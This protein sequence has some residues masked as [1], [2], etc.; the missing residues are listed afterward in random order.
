MYYVA[1]ICK[2]VVVGGSFRTRSTKSVMFRAAPAA[3]A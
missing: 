2:Y 3:A 1:A